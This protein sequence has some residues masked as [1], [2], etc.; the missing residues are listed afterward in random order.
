MMDEAH[1]PLTFCSQDTLDDYCGAK[2]VMVSWWM[3]HNLRP[4]VKHACEHE[5]NPH[6][7]AREWHKNVCRS[8][9]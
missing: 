3:Q 4:C 9:P 7:R 6:G 8:Y 1:Q 5:D 2:V